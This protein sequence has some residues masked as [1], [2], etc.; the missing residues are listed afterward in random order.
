[1]DDAGDLSSEL[2][3][4]MFE[5]P[6]VTPFVKHATGRAKTQK[7]R[8]RLNIAEKGLWHWSA[9]GVELSLSAL[10]S[11]LV[12]KSAGRGLA[13]SLEVKSYAQT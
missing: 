2:E 1:M 11:A 3:R 6:S 4:G 5:L 12:E 9:R 10:E 8:N 13:R 7:N